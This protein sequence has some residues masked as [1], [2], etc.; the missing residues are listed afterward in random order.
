MLD[1][2]EDWEIE[3]I[4]LEIGKW[5]SLVEIHGKVSR[6]ARDILRAGG[7]VDSSD[8]VGSGHRVKLV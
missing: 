2:K 4:L 7:S 8:V 5:T 6:E 1:G 3:D